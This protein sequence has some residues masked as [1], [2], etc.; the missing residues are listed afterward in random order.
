MI[1]RI[2][3]WGMLVS[4]ASFAMAAVT[5]DGTSMTGNGTYSGAINVSNATGQTVTITPSGILTLGSTVTGSGTIIN[6]NTTNAAK[7]QLNGD[8]SDFSGT[9]ETSGVAWTEVFTSDFANTAWKVA[10]TNAVA[11]CAS[12]ESTTPYTFY[13][14]TLYG[15]DSTT[16]VRS[17]GSSSKAPVKVVVGNTNEAL[18]SDAENI[19]AGK[20]V[21]NNVLGLGIEKVGPGVWTLSGTNTYSLGTTIS[22]GTLRVTGSIWENSIVINA[23]GTLELSGSGSLTASNLVSGN[24]AITNNGTFCI[25]KDDAYNL[26]RAVTGTGNLVKDGSGT[27]SVTVA[28]DYS[29]YT[30]VKGGT[31]SS[32]YAN[33]ASRDFRIAEGAMLALA[34]STDTT[35]NATVS[36]TGTF[37]KS[38]SSKLLL[39]GA[40]FSGFSGTVTTT[41]ERWIE[42]FD[43]GSNTTVWNINGSQGLAFATNGGNS[44]FAFG[45]LTGSG[46]IIISNG[47]STDKAVTLTVGN[48]NKALL[49][50]AENIFSGTL[51]DRSSG[52]TLAVEKIGPGTWTLSGANTYTGG[53]TVA[54]G[55]LKIADTGSVAS[56][57]TVNADTGN[58]TPALIL[59]GTIDGNLNL[60][61]IF[62]V[63]FT[64][65]LTPTGEV[66]GEVLFGDDALLS[67]LADEPS[68]AMRYT[69]NAGS[70]DFGTRSLAEIY[71]DSVAAGLLADIWIP[72]VDG[73]SIILS[74]DGSK[75]PEPASCL[76]LLLGLCLG[77]R[78]FP[79][80]SLRKG[81]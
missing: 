48:G 45:A 62:T 67:I 50:D 73:T 5:F 36:G 37:A 42:L 49:S 32:N 8:W 68:S 59:E 33:L 79:R 61:G 19:F 1:K 14:G 46:S 31:L 66:T 72:S 3:F 22:G 69:L 38:G 54:G 70:L 43:A 7:L 77:R 2:F 13:L 35:F 57:V 40:D 27:L 80:P 21:D 64:N 47:Q 81:F 10:G 28:S 65:G 25:N 44:S 34:F 60:N 29:G 15:G 6:A 20:I 12:A 78:F 26:D 55:T 4:C 11:F 58:D 30:E 18:V 53:T 76:L 71:S 23:G 16:E 41:G 9:Y 74:V 56:S 63:D 24:D 75:V 51:A 52:G 17:S 39:R